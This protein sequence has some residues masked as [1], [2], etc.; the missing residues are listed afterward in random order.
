MKPSKGVLGPHSKQDVDGIIE[1]EGGCYY[2]KYE[3]LISSFLNI[4]LLSCTC[5]FK[6]ISAITYALHCSFVR[7][8]LHE[9]EQAVASSW[10]MVVLHTYGWHGKKMAAALMCTK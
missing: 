4:F 5:T 3:N 10:S 2:L 8:Q 1:G 6:I 7:Q 9:V